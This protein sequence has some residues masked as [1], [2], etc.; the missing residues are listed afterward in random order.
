[1]T[2]EQRR[3]APAISQALL[4]AKVAIATAEAASAPRPTVHDIRC[5]VR[6][7]LQKEVDF[8]CNLDYVSV[9]SPDTGRELDCSQDVPAG[10]ILSTAVLLGNE[11][12]LRLLDNVVL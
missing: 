10:S 11:P 9:S 5:H 7:L 1:M 3:W 6:E 8:I 12:P 4:S 2:D